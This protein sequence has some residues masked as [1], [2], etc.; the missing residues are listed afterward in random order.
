MALGLLQDHRRRRRAAPSS[1]ATNY[2]RDSDSIATMG[3]AIAGALGGASRGARGVGGDGG[4]ASPAGPR[5]QRAGHGRGRR[6]DLRRR[7]GGLRAARGGGPGDCRPLPAPT[8]S[9]S[10]EVRV[11]WAQPED[12]LRHELRQSADEG[13]DVADVRA[14]V[15][16]RR[17]SGRAPRRRRLARSGHARSRSRWPGSCWTSWTRMPAPERGR[18][19]E[20]LAGHRRP[21]SATCR[22]AG[23]S[24]ARTR[25]ALRDR[26]HGAWLGRAVGCVLGKPVEKIPRAGIEEILRSQGR[27]PLDRWFTAVGLDPRGGRAL[28]VEHGEPADQPRGEHR[29]HAG[30]RRPQLH[31][32]GAED[33]RAARRRLHLRRRGAR[34]G[35]WTCRPGGRS[36]PSGSPTATCWTGYLPPETARVR[37]PFREWIG[38]QI[39]TDLYGW[40]NPGDV[41]RAAEWAWRDAAVSHTRNGIYGAMYAAALG[42]VRGGGVQHRARCWT[43]RPRWC[44]RPAGW[45]G[46]SRSGR[47]LADAESSRPRRTRGWRRSSPTCTGCTR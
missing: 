2:G 7:R 39:R 20:R 17:G 10:A 11:T 44:R 43:R 6:G 38:A 18:R 22:A 12:L 28:A 42:R 8:R 3:G 35:C 23:Y 30:G 36:P 13:R 5:G 21:P 1:G 29:R 15:G 40:V 4:R 24:R 46:R 41:L 16:R 32:A 25:T 33:P 37:N 19:A 9:R 14:S 31:P 34:P 27:W 26:V 45:P 47:E